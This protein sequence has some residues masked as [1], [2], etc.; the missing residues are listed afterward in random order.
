MESAEDAWKAAE[1]IGVPVV[2]K[3]TDGNHGRGVFTDLTNRGAV[4]AAYEIA[5]EEGSGVIVERFVPGL[6]H[7]LLVVGG[8]V[9]AAAKG[10]LASVVGDGRSTI[11]ELV[12]SQLNSD[13]RRGD[14]EDFPLN[15]VRMNSTVRADL[16]RQGF[17]PESVPPAGTTVLI[18]RNGNVAFDVTDR[19]HPDVAETA[20]SPRAWSDSTSRESTWWRKT[21]GVRSTSRAAR[22][23]RSTP[24]P[25]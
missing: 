1:E 22:S 24:V 8:R 21:W 7:R 14:T 16:A 13:P 3:P 12:Q 15:P 25:A 5:R 9:A 17:T 18:Q 20:C 11:R 23:S 10:E 19:V 6:E 2:V 4:E